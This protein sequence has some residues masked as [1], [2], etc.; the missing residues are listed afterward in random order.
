VIKAFFIFPYLY[1]KV[2]VPGLPGARLQK[3]TGFMTA[4]RLGDDSAGQ[5]NTYSTLRTGGTIGRKYEKNCVAAAL[6]LLGYR[7]KAEIF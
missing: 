7:Q 5:C 6:L 2:S 1:G 4:H 3:K